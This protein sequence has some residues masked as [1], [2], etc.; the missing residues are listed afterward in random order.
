[1]RITAE[2]RK[3]TRQKI[4]D[5]SL[6]LFRTKG[7]D[8]TTSRDI[9][10]QAQIANGTLFNY[11]PHKEAIVLQLACDALER[12]EAAFRKRRREG[13]DLV[14]DLFLH[15]STGLRQMAAFR[16]FVGSALETHLGPATDDAV[17]EQ[18]TAI[19]LQHIETVSRLISEHGRDEPLT[20]LQLQMYWLLFSGVLAFW[21]KDSSRK[22]EDT[23]ALLDQSMR[24]F[25]AWLSEPGGSETNP[26]L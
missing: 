14:E 5:C 12:T 4:L 21:A 13:A 24:M 7:F 2:A 22:Q 23:L 10:R 9:A 20:A 17:C 19:R 11:F 26:S 16:T 18:A 8:E 15:V 1:M 3:Q 6:E 25:V